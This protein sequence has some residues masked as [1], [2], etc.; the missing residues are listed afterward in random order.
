MPNN[1]QPNPFSNLIGHTVECCFG[2]N[3]TTALDS[4]PDVKESPEVVDVSLLD[5]EHEQLLVATQELLPAEPAVDVIR[6]RAA[7]KHVTPV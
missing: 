1:Y 6:A 4:A 7:V 3:F 5:V 2:Y